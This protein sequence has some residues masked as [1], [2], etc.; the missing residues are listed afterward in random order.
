MLRMTVLPD[1]QQ[2]CASDAPS[3]RVAVHDWRGLDAAGAA[4]ELGAL[5]E[6]LVG[7][8][9]A[10]DRWPLFSVAVSLEA[11]VRRLHLSLDLLIV[12][13]LSLFRLLRQWGELLADPASLP[14]PPAL[15]FRDYVLYLRSLEG[16]PAWQAA[17]RYW[18]AE[19]PA[20]P[21]APVLPA[22]R[23]ADAEEQAATRRYQ[24]GLPAEAWARLR[25]RARA[26]DVTPVAL[27]LT[28]FAEVLGHW[29][30]SR[31]FTLN[32]TVYDRRP[33]HPDIQ[34]VVGD[35]TSTLLLGLDL[36]KPETVAGRV[37]AVAE[38][39]TNGL[40]HS[41][42]NGVRVLR[43][44]PADAEG[45]RPSMPVV[46]T[47]MLGYG[48][49]LGSTEGRLTRLGRL[50][51]GAT[52]TPHVSLDAQVI[53]DEEGGLSLTWD[54]VDGL[55]QPGLMGLMIEAYGALVRRLAADAEAWERS[56]GQLIAEAEQARRERRNA[57]TAPI[58]PD[59]LHEP[60]VRQA[61]A[62]PLRPAIVTLERTV[63]Y[64]E[65]LEKAA[66][67][68]RLLDD[69]APN[70]LVAVAIEKGWLQVA[71]VL[72]I[73]LAG[74]AYLPIEPTL[75]QERIHHL[76]RR[77]E[78]RTVLTEGDS[79]ISW[80]SGVRVVDAGGIAPVEV[81][82]M[83][84]RRCRPEDL[85]YVIF[86]SGS[87]GEPKGVMID[88]R[89][90]LNTV[91]DINE[92]FG[93]GP[94]DRVLGLSALGFD[95]SV[96]DIFGPLAVGGALVLPRARSVA[97]PAHQAECVSR[98]GVTVWNSVPMFL[99]LF[100]EGE[101]PAEVVRQLRLVML[102]GDW[103]PLTLPP[104]LWALAPE[105][106]LVS[107]GGA[108]EASIWSILYPFDRIDPKWTSVPYGYPMR[109]QSFFILDEALEPCPDGVPGELFIGGIGLAQGYW[110]DP[111][112]TA[113]S[114]IR[115]PRT[116]E[117]LYRTGDLGRYGR[118]GIIEFLGRR[119]G[120]V[121]VGGYRIE[122]GEVEAALARHPG[123]AE[124]VAIAIDEG[125][126]KRRLVAF[127]RSRRGAEPTPAELAELLRTKLPAYMVPSRI[128]MVEAFPL[129]S[130]GKV[131][132][133]AL[134]AGTWRGERPI[135]VALPAAALSEARGKPD[136]VAEGLQRVLA[137]LLGRSSV[138]PTA[139]FF[140]LGVDSL[141]AVAANRRFRNELELDCTVT[142]L[143]EHPSIAALAR[144][145]CGGIGE[146]GE[147]KNGEA[148][149]E[150]VIAAMAGMETLRADRRALRR[151]FRATFG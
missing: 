87:T 62:D 29:A 110:R 90:A 8:R 73:H 65:L 18:A 146:Q 41:L 35:F 10:P 42:F 51:H 81:A 27:L 53:E 54:V 43:L 139:S 148:G 24:V 13:V 107:L 28:A 85:A 130:N 34:A 132:R 22:G 114:F 78:A 37:R 99:N 72:G 75:P 52:Q 11:G 120:Q 105:A 33:V 44:L 122:L 94:E 79:G 5:R 39:L 89:G 71:A 151:Q 145:L 68:A 101:P 36:A 134:A 57:T 55:F 80:P 45:R 4:R 109:N 2:R 95:L 1:G 98:C 61:L 9:F 102:S 127:C 12:D 6:R 14:A 123:V 74:A 58:S 119:D 115:Y 142:D 97:D 121:K 106:K 3:Y 113:A 66:G 84:G 126:G 7:E 17:E 147:R 104:R 91:L 82:A 93:I 150:P 136:A 125:G 100:L 76:L 56:A 103:I 143:F 26:A 20:L 96:Y 67:I 140:E 31:R 32:L 21:P 112:R 47:S 111:E 133:N 141:T 138:D 92:R 118:D 59:L 124:A 83:P 137:E 131:D 117:H 40:E 49:A 135:E 30:E 86:T 70:Q 19:G 38:R 25:E 77:G 144:H 129:N 15:S 64:G 88:H 23:R 69:A 116:G 149:A 16:G 46:F 60:F 63:S 50:S 48:A 128:E 108:T